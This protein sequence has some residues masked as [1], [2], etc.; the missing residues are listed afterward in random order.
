MSIASLLK[1][2][3][4][5]LKLST[6]ELAHRL[7]ISFVAVQRVLAASSQP[8]IRTASKYARFLGVSMGKLE[9][10][11]EP[12]TRRRRSATSRKSA[13]ASSSKRRRAR[14]A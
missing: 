2:R 9:R 4:R 3:Q 10:M 5:E 13:N 11:M 8:N 7:R 14:A 1:R 12:R 6:Y